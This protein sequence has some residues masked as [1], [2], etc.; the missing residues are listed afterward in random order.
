MDAFAMQLDHV[1]ASEPHAPS[2]IDTAQQ[3]TRLSTTDL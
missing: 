2:L 3:Q 1:N